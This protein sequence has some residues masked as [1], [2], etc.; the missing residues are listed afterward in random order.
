MNDTGAANRK[1]RIFELWFG[2]S[3]PVGRSAYA[4]SGLGLMLLKY[5]ADAALVARVTGKVWTPLSY[6]HPFLFG[7]EVPLGTPPSW[8]IWMLALWTVPFLWVG[9]SLSIRRA[10]DAGLS[11]WVGCLFFIPLI[12]YVLMVAL[13][14][15][16]SA[17]ERAWQLLN[18]RHAVE[19]RFVPFFL[20]AAAGSGVMLGMIGLSVYVLRSYGAGLF[21]G[22]P[23]C[24]GF[25]VGFLYNRTHWRSEWAT[26]AA[27]QLS[28][29]IAG[30][31]LLLFALEG[32][33]C[34]AMA[35]PLAAV[36]ALPGGVI[37]RLV[38]LQPQVRAAHLTVMLLA[39]PMLTGA[40][41]MQRYTPLREVVSVIDI[42]ASPA[43]VWPHVVGFSELPPPS[44]LVFRLG[45]AYPQRARI[46]GTGVGAVRHCEFSTG[47]FVEPIT[48][49]EVPL[50]LSFDVVG[51]P[52]PMHEWSPYRH[53]NAP[54]LVGNM[55]SKRGEFRLIALP[56]GHTRLEGSTWY[57]LEMFPQVYWTRWSDALIHAIH[58]RVLQH[59]KHLS[60]AAAAAPPR[61]A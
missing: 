51:Q 34:V 10:V 6:L 15:L 33:V 32:A 7:R 49:W 38:A 42:A 30:C 11:P 54:H 48:R 12:N 56:N 37:G 5:T 60:E 43:G 59:I 1:H 8:L 58:M 45:I 36:I 18:A 26:I 31:A 2:L 19:D 57:E 52:P 47:A 17:S 3:R 40:E 35:Y 23:F 27:V 44:Q 50:R 46:D 55:R 14:I 13:C 9:V 22:T 21:L 25:V 4:L 16:P 39:L 61:Q 28:I 53:V 24:A 29:L 41:S 20:S